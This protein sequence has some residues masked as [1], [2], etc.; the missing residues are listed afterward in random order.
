MHPDLD[1]VVCPPFQQ[2]GKHLQGEQL[3]CHALVRKMC[4]KTNKCH[5]YRFV[6]P[7]EGSPEEQHH[8]M[9]KQLTDLWELCVYHGSEGCIYV[10]E[11]R[12]CH[13]RLHKRSYQE[14]P[15]SDQVQSK[16]LRE[17]ARHISYV[18]PIDEAVN[19]SPEPLPMHSLHR[20]R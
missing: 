15:A 2:Q 3:V 9:Q 11:A 5:R 1:R 14:S 6:A 4:N 19:T 13:L 7:S 18:R 17:D 20:V 8:A 12:R 16:Q 10:R